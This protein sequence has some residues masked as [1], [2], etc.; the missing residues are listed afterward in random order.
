MFQVYKKAY[1]KPFKSCLVLDSFDE[2]HV[3]C[4]KEDEC[5]TE[6]ENIDDIYQQI[7]ICWKT[8]D[9]EPLIEILQQFRNWID[10]NDFQY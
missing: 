6:F 9:Y 4:Q 3:T 10:R 2:F 8:I 5:F 7:E 1:T